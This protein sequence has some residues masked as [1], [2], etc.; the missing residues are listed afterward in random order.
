AN[1]IGGA[2]AAEKKKNWRAATQEVERLKANWERLGP[3]IGE[4][5][6]TLSDRFHKAYAH[7]FELRKTPDPGGR[8]VKHAS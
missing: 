4:V 1:T 5:G 8:P 6:Q 7:F 3:V 2:P